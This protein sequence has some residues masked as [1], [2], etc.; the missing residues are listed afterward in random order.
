MHN[1]TMLRE[2]SKL[3]LRR[4]ALKVYQIQQTEWKKSRICFITH[5]TLVF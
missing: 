5:L 3:P 1:W 2:V 4:H